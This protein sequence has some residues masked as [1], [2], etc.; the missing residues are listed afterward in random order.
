VGVGEHVRFTANTA[1]TWSVSEGRIIGLNTGANIVWEA[2]A[3]AANPT[4]TLTTPGGTRVIP[5][6]VI[7]PN[8][9]S[10]VVATRDAIPVGTAGACMITNVT[11]NPLNV[12]F[13]RTQWLEVPGPAT[14]VSGY[15]NQFPAALLFHNPNPAYLPFD[16]ANTGLTDHAAFHAVPAPFSLGTFEWVIPNRY[17]I[18]GEPDARGRLFVNTVQAFTMF[19]GGTMTITKAGAFVLR[20]TGN[21]II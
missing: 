18:D 2:P 17:K 20:T 3:V 7:A 4:I 21:F 1:G 5:F 10:M 6:T 9:L 16:D 14:N 15:F 11:V 19:P 13:G 8:A 12:N